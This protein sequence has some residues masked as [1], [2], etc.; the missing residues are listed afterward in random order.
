MN[1]EEFSNQ[2]QHAL[3]LQIGDQQS[4]IL[5]SLM[6]ERL[7]QYVAENEAAKSWEPLLPRG[8]QRIPH[9]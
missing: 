2:V 7:R 3:Q 4:F 1:E 8:Y 5:G 9:S 6:L